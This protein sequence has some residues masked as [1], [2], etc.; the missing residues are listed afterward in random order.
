M[1]GLMVLMM[2]VAFIDGKDCDYED[3]N[4]FDYHDDNCLYQFFA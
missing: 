1:M 3:H 2:V 4:N